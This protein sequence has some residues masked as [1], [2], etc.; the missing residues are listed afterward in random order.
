MLMNSSLYILAIYRRCGNFDETSSLEAQV[1]K[2]LPDDYE[3]ILEDIGFHIL[4][5]VA[6]GSWYF[7]HIKILYSRRW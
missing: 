4:Q 2:A 7:K 3:P 6:K 5:M 1:A